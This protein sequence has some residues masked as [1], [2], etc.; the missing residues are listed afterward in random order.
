MQN[1]ESKY[2]SLRVIIKKT[3]KRYSPVIILQETHIFSK[4]LDM[5]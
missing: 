3:L 4:T 1:N 2:H 5:A